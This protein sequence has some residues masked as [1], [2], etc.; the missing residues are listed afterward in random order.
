MSESKFIILRRE[1]LKICQG[2]FCAA[3]LIEYFRNWTKWKTEVQRT[4][5][6]YQPL[7]NIHGDLMGEH[8]LH[9]IRSAIA[10]LEENKIISKRQ[11]P[12]NKQDKTYQYRLNIDL[13]WALLNKESPESKIEFPEFRS[14]HSEFNAERHHEINS[15]NHPLFSNPTDT[16]VGEKKVGC[17]REANQLPKEITEEQPNTTNLINDN[18]NHTTIT[19]DFHGGHFPAPNE[20]NNQNLNQASCTTV[21]LDPTIEDESEE[22]ESVGITSDELREITNQ[23]R[24]IQVTP[25]L[26]INPQIQAAIKKYPQYVQNA[27]AYLKE[28]IAANIKPKKSWE[29]WLVF[30][31]VSGLKPEKGVAPSNFKDWFEAAYKKGLVIAS[32]LR[33]D[34]V[35]GVCLTEA[36]ALELGVSQ[37]VRFEKAFEL[38][39]QQVQI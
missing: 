13:L 39:Q 25:A 36:V 4:S 32:E 21:T 33:G 2:N 30:A 8:S 23:L 29:A 20:N 16:A 28:Q 7:K 9:V 34:G 31:I 11:N 1:F 5:W 27:I 26:R 6:I 17:V 24:G 15:S 10:F 12:G 22:F 38:L 14:E 18:T 35:T 19:E 3:K 37:W